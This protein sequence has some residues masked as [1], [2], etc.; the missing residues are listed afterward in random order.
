MILGGL[1]K[2]TL[3][4]YPGKL[5]AI[6]FVSGCSFR[7]GFCYNPELVLPE[8]IKEHP[9]ISEDFIFDF[10]KERQGMLEGVVITGGEPTIQR[11]LPD[12]LKKIKNLGYSVKLDSNGSNPEM[13]KELIDKK[14]IDY[15]A[16]DIKGP[17]EKYQK[18]TGAEVDLEKIKKSVEL[19]KNSNIDYEFRSTILPIV[20][21][22]ED[23]VNMAKWISG[24]KVYYLQQFRPEKTLDPKYEKYKPFSQEQ[25]KEIQKECNKNVLTKLR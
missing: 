8:K 24:A 5:A 25:L 3:I 17:R 7:C 18:I 14:L 21:T 10:L 11:D 6:I 22:K 4:D 16:L 13:L 1:Q 12:F 2:L 9:K 19:A 20:H 23:I 15:I